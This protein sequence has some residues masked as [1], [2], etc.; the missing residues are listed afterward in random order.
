VATVLSVLFFGLLAL[1][2][3][4]QAKM[5]YEYYEIP[6]NYARLHPLELA[7]IEWMR[8][9]LSADS[10]VLTSNINRHTEWIE[11]L[12]PLRWTPLSEN[13][14]L[15]AHQPPPNAHPSNRL[16]YVMFLLNREDVP[17]SA[18]QEMIPVYQNKGA[19]VFFAPIKA[20]DE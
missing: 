12:T 20:G 11:A 1:P 3:W 17:A 2:A 10:K 18:W 9:N 4:Q 13:S 8:D 5:T 14:P 15:L 16:T 7:A 19:V 6:D